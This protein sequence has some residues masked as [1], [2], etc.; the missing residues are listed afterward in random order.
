[1]NVQAARSVP[2]TELVHKAL[3]DWHI[4]VQQCALRDDVDRGKIPHLEYCVH[5]EECCKE[6]QESSH[7][8]QE[9]AQH[10]KI[11]LS[12]C[13]SDMHARLMSPEPVNSSTPCH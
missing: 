13:L 7:Q 11:S 5:S 9:P 12:V 6:Q 1:M 3:L 4:R 10:P 8:Q 2:S